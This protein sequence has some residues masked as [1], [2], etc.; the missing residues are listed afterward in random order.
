MYARA[1]VAS[2]WLGRAVARGKE[3]AVR[4]AWG[5]GR[6]RLLRQ[7]LTESMLLAVLAGAIS[8]PLGGWIL[9]LLI[10]QIASALPSFWG[11]IA[12][13]LT[14][15]FRIFAYTVLVS[16]G[17]GIAFGLSPALQASKADVN[18]ALK[19]EGSAFGQRISS[20]RLRGL[21]IAGQVAACLLLLI[22]SAL[23]LRG[24]Q[25]ALK[26]EPGYEALHV[27]SLERYDPANLHYS[28]ARLLQ[29]KRDIIEGIVSLPGL[30]LVTHVPPSPLASIPTLPLPHQLAP[31]S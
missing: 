21:L 25:R 12:L 15:D 2:L 11:A 13:E 5:A 7:L 30:Q 17:A 6:W 24:S 16:C 26:I 23:L 10:L 18:S 9:H 14:P 4:M 8:L 3:I 20:S 31:L 29:L 22:T 28:Q 27:V 1:N 19:E